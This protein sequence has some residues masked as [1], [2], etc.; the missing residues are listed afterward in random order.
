MKRSFGFKLVGAFMLMLF[1]IATGVGIYALETMKN[2]TT[3][4][5]DDHLRRDLVLGQDLLKNVFPGEWSIEGDRIQKGPFQ[6][7]KEFPFIDRLSRLTGNEVMFYNAR[8]DLIATSKEEGAPGSHKIA[9]VHVSSILKEYRATLI[10]AET[11]DSPMSIGAMPVFDQD[12]N[13]IGF[14]TVNFPVIQFNSMANEMQVKMMVGAYAAMLVTGFIFYILTGFISKPITQIVDG[15]TRAEGGDLSVRL[16]INTRDE[17]AFLGEKFNSMIEN[18]A[19]LI[20][21]ILAVAEQVA[22]SA[23][24]LNSGARESSKTTEQIAATI[25]VVAAGAEDQVKSVE[26]TSTVIGDMSKGIQEV[27]DHS[28][29]V[30]TI[31]LKASNTASS[32]A[33]LV[34]DAVRQMEYINQTSNSTANLVRTLD[35]KSKRIS[36]IVDVITGIAKQTNLLALNAAIEAA[37]AGEQGRGF[38]VVAEEVRKLAEQ[39]GGAAKEIAELILEI[40]AETENAVKAMESGIQE[41]VNGTGVVNEAGIAFGDIVQSINDVTQRIHEV[42]V[43]AEQMAVGAEQ[44]VSAVENVA[45]ISQEAATSA[46]E[47]AAAAQQQTASIEEVAT[48]AGKLARLA[49]DLR[50]MVMNFKL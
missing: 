33:E 35:D 17:F 25:H 45:G 13:P 42:S 1:C 18:L 48:S 32:G 3:S 37:R 27:A 12:G 11:S 24:N 30:L 22:T 6:V 4:M 39:S 41:V 36:Y 40:R 5:I 19:G 20:K 23:E 15:M 26:Q 34:Q 29:D 46:E 8:G 14:W 2:F 50:V 21:N 28:Q 9:P 10:S 38:A 31:S 49:E 43:S 44:A 7:D 16:H 47:V